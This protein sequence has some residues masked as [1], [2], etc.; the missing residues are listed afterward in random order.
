[1]TKTHVEKSLAYLSAS[2]GLL[3]ALAGAFLLGIAFVTSSQRAP[4]GAGATCLSSAFVLLV[5]ATSL[6]R[7]VSGVRSTVASPR[8]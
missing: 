6:F 5:I 2:F 8:C 3:S 7:K 1:M 4:Y